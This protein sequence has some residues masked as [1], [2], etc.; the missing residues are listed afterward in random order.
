MV[1]DPQVFVGTVGHQQLLIV[2]LV[3]DLIEK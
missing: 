3:T 1:F 2:L